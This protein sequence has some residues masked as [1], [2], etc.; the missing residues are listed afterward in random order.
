[1]TIWRERGRGI[2]CMWIIKDSFDYWT[3]QPNILL[4]CGS[5]QTCPG[6]LTLPAWISEPPLNIIVAP[7]QEHQDQAQKAR[8]DWFLV[9]SE[10]VTKKL[11][12]SHVPLC[13]K[14]GSGRKGKIRTCREEGHR[15][16]CCARERQCEVTHS[17]LHI[18]IFALIKKLNQQWKTQFNF[19][20]I[21][22]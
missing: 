20:A 16:L 19:S 21:C 17:F 2:I 10:N 22:D 5:E 18:L 13:S 6:T 7:P 4:L 14:T 12:S 15:R 1:M 8:H 3:P 9:C 11:L